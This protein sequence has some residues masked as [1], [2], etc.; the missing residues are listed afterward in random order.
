MLASDSHAAILR[1][2]D[3]ITKHVLSSCLQLVRQNY[4]PSSEISTLYSH[5]EVRSLMGQNPLSTEML[6]NNVANPLV[7]PLKEQ[8]DIVGNTLIPFLAK[9]Q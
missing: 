9:T 3:L 8:L 1:T 4:H 7:F 2:Q 6:K 5:Q